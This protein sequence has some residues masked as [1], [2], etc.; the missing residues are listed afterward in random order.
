M[1]R[2]QVLK[3]DFLELR[4]QRIPEKPQETCAISPRCKSVRLVASCELVELE[5]YVLHF[6][7]PKSELR[8]RYDGA[9]G[10]PLLTRVVGHIQCEGTNRVRGRHTLFSVAA[11]MC[12]RAPSQVREP[13]APSMKGD[14]VRPTKPL[15]SV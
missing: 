5:S 14:V 12:R 3:F 9:R 11:D 6:V 13:M 15:C 7:S 10:V 2:T 1:P 8:A 4:V